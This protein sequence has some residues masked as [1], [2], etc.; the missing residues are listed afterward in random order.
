[1]Q[2]N[3]KE[4]LDRYFVLYINKKYI[5]VLHQILIKKNFYMQK[6]YNRKALKL[7]NYMI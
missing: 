6:I 2:I 3:S 5:Y 4:T 7:R 1:M